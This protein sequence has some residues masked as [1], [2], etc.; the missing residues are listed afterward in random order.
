MLLLC[1]ETPH[2]NFGEPYIV[3]KLFD[4]VSIFHS[5]PTAPQSVSYNMIVPL[6]DAELFH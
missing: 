6:D 2:R 1:V 4:Q 5:I 3:L